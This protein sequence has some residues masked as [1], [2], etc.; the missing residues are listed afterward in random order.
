M[1]RVILHAAT[2]CTLQQWLVYAARAVNESGTE[3]TNRRAIIRLF[4][5]HSLTGIKSANCARAEYSLLDLAR[6]PE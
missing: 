4:V 1:K 2:N 5:G 6:E 3:Y